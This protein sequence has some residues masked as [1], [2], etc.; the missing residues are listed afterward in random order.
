MFYEQQAFISILQIC[1]L[2]WMC[3]LNNIRRR[4]NKY[5]STWIALDQ[6]MENMSP[7]NIFYSFSH[8]MPQ[9]SSKNSNPFNLFFYYKHQDQGIW[10]LL[11]PIQK[12]QRAHDKA[13]SKR[14]RVK[15]HKN[16]VNFLSI[17]TIP[18]LSTYSKNNLYNLVPCSSKNK[19]EREFKI[20]FL[21]NYKYIRHPDLRRM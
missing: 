21:N 4:K 19:N 9:K 13:S 16:C 7:N 8:V 1:S 17:P 12:N 18:T 20:P 6:R 10:T 15:Q 5:K 14:T 2:I 11:Y 3:H